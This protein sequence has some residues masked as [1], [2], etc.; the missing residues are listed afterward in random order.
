[1]SKVVG[2][3]G[4]TINTGQPN[5]ALVNGLKELL[6]MA[7]SGQLQS[8]IGVGLTTDDQVINFWCDTCTNMYTVLGT[9]AALPH[10]FIARRT[11]PK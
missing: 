2:I 10:Q 3:D 6:V 11:L 4:K 9:L 5:Q 8:F 7:E 1:M